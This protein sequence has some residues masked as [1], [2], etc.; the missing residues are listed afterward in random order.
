MAQNENRWPRFLSCTPPGS[1]RDAM[2]VLHKEILKSACGTEEKAIQPTWL[3]TVASVGSV[4]VKLV[5]NE[6]GDDPNHPHMSLSPAGCA[7][8]SPKPRTSL[9]TNRH[10]VAHQ[11]HIVHHILP[12]LPIS[13]PSLSRLEIKF[14]FFRHQLWVRKCLREH[15]GFWQL[16]FIWIRFG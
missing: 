4:G 3:L 1:D 2:A 16:K 14:L 11:Y 6:G 15:V 12:P 13:R 8:H 9:P 7:S 5:E 10:A